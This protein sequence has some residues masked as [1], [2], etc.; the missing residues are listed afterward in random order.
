MTTE[1]ADRPGAHVSGQ[2]TVDRAISFNARNYGNQPA[3]EFANSVLTYRELDRD[4]SAVANGLRD[5]GI[6]RHDRV[7]VLLPNS[8][9]HFLV[10]MAIYRCGAT[11]VGCSTSFVDDEIEY[12]LI[13]SRASAAITTDAFVGQLRDMARRAA[14]RLTVL[15]GDD[16][17]TLGASDVGA[18]VQTMSGTWEEQPPD[19]DDLAVIFYTSGST[20]RPKG[21]MWTNAAYYT[22]ARRCRDAF[23]YTFGERVLDHFPMYHAMGGA[24]LLAPALLVAGTIVI[25]PRFSASGFIPTVRDRKITMTALNSTHVK[26]LLSTPA[27]PH[28][29][30]HSLRRAMFGLSIDLERRTEFTSRFGIRLIGFHGMT[31]IPG[32]THSVPM[33]AN[34]SVVSGGL[35]APDVERRIVDAADRDVALGGEG[36]LILRSSYRGGTCDGYLDD[37]EATDL[38]FRRGWLRTGDI[39]RLDEDGY[40]D[41]VTRIKDVIK[42]RG[43]NVSGAEVE[44]ILLSHPGVREAAVVGIP[45]SDTD[46]AIIAFVVSEPGFND[47]EAELDALCTAQLAYYKRPARFLRVAEFPYDHV[48]KVV[49]RALRTIAQQ[50]VPNSETPGATTTA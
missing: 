43:Y 25:L 41:F 31:E 4:V 36:E 3:V 13:H 28:E 30:E 15:T 40:I 20:A 5:R 1:S 23:G 18:M 39:M 19:P 17:D 16:P 26:Y 32:I 11:Y 7:F 37:P 48:G 46:E 35:P 49:K 27:G 34:Y 50:P 9:E 24:S 12:Q 33:Y 10:M 22:G 6:A 47:L 2:L 8:L 14:R 44:R 29:R 21:V 42:C 38:L 45:D